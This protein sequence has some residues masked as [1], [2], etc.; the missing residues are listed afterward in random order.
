MTGLRLVVSIG[1]VVM[2]LAGCAEKPIVWRVS[3]EQQYKRDNYQCVRDSQT[4]GGG[5]GIPGAIAG[6]QAQNDANRLYR[7]CMEA[8]GY[9]EAKSGGPYLGLRG[10]PVESG[11]RVQSVTA[12]GPAENA[13]LRVGDVIAQLDGRR[14]VTLDDLRAV[15]DSKSPGERMNLVV[16]REGAE[17]RITLTV[18]RR[19]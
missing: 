19:P 4:F 2:A 7:M 11:I 9:T 5:S 12:G 10:Q 15:V 3:D 16:M 13:G 8:R 18:G 14:M 17:Q 1:Y 6:I